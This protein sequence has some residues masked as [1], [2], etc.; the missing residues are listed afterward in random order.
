MLKQMKFYPA[1]V[2]ETFDHPDE[3]R[4]R[5]DNEPAFEKARASIAQ[6]KPFPFVVASITAAD[7]DAA[8]ILVPLPEGKIAACLY[9]LEHMRATQEEAQALAEE[10]T[11][12]GECY[13]GRTVLV[14]GV[15]ATLTGRA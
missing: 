14:M 13:H 5:F 15:D 6:G 12:T 8:C 2:I 4:P 1:T 7:P 3:L 10:I 9:F 11:A